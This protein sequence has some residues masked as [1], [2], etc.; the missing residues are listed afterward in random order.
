MCECPCCFHV[1]LWWT[2]V[3]PLGPIDLSFLQGV[4]VRPKTSLLPSVYLLVSLWAACRATKLWARKKKMGEKRGFSL[5]LMFFFL[6]AGA[7]A[8]QRANG[9]DGEGF[10]GC[11]TGRGSMCPYQFSRWSNYWFTLWSLALSSVNHKSVHQ[12]IKL[13]GPGKEK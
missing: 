2:C 3:K 11:Q 7:R 4:T 5:H 1:G 6:T 8:R 9:Q 13:S 10:L 12:A